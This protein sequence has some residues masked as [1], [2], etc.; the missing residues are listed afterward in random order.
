MDDKLD[1]IL[2]KLDKMDNRITNI[3]MTLENVTNRNIQIIAEGHAGLNEKLDQA[4]K[5]E[6]SIELTK[7]RV[8]ILEGELKK[9]NTQLNMA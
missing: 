8:N 9:I 2:Q 1:I 4:I 6:N 3:E 7:I 5:A